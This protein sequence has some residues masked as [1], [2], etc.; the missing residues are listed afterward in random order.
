MAQKGNDTFRV[1]I[2]GYESGSEGMY[3][4]WKQRGQ[5]KEK[6]LNCLCFQFSPPHDNCQFG[7][8]FD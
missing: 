7:R 1:A 8:T 5:E 6:V 2:C 4:G 3:K